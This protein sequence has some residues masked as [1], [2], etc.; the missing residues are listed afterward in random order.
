MFILSAKIVE[1]QESI[2]EHAIDYKIRSIL[3]M[4]IAQRVYVEVM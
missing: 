1:W 3:Y 4:F 2:S